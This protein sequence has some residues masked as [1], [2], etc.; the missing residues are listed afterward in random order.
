MTTLTFQAASVGAQFRPAG[1]KDLIRSLAI[2]DELTLEREPENAY[3]AN[4]IKVLHDT[5][6]I[7]YIEAS[8]AADL[9]H[10]IDDPSYTV[11]EVTILSF[12]NSVKPHLNITL[13]EEEGDGDGE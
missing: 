2:G 7:G 11:T 4:A 9:A 5:T 1:T 6:H 10:L 12:L 3:D 8:V 13:V